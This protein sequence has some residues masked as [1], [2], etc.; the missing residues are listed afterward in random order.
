MCVYV[1]EAFVSFALQLSITGTMVI[2]QMGFA[3]Q[4]A[5]MQS[6]A[7]SSVKKSLFWNDILYT[8][9]VLICF[10]NKIQ[11][12]FSVAIELPSAFMCAMYNSNRRSTCKIYFC[13]E[14]N[15]ENEYN[16]FG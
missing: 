7:V 8:F 9:F 5:K 6:I 3:I 10:E 15:I 16:T 11:V 2:F 13:L 14:K 12:I 1:M 4:S